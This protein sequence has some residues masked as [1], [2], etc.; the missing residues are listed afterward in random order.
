MSEARR[1]L[2]DAIYQLFNVRA[3]ILLTMAG[4]DGLS[5]T[6]ALDVAGEVDR[7]SRA[8]EVCANLLTQTIN[9]LDGSREA[10]RRAS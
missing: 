3:I 4:A 10:F 2:D 6:V 8:T 7:I 5:E 1:V 9:M